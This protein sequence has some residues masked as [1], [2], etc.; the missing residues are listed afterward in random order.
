MKKITLVILMC[1]VALFA[2][3]QVIMDES[4]NYS[5][6]SLTTEPSW[7]A[8]NYTTAVVGT[9]GDLS[10]DPLSYGDGNGMYALS[11]VGK[12]VTSNYTSGA[13]D[14]K[15]VKSI[16]PVSSGVIYMSL[17]FKPGVAQAQ[18]N[19]E[20]MCLS[21][22]GS[23]GPKVLIGKG[24]I[25]TT[26]FRFATTRASSSS[27]DYKWA[28]TEYT[29]INQTFLLVVKYDWSNS[30]A[31]L[32]V[33]PV[34][35]S[36]TEPT[37]DVIDNNGGP[38][39]KTVSAPIDG[40]RFR[41]NGASVSKFMVS[42]VRISSSWAAAVGKQV[43][44]LSSPTANA[45]SSVT[46]NSFTANWTPVANAI[47]YD[48]AVYAGSTLL[49]TVNATGQSTSSLTIP[50]L[51]SNTAYTYQVTAVADK[52]TF[53]NSAP[54]SSSTVVTTL[55]LTA[56]TAAAATNISTSGFTANWSS[57]SSA[58]GYDI[59]LL[60]N[61]TQ[62][63]TINVTGG[64]VTSY[65]FTQL[66]MG[67]TYNYKVVAKGNGSGILDSTPSGTIS[68]NTLSQNIT[69]ATTDFSQVAIWGNPI[70]TPSTNLPLSGYYPTW[71]AAGFTFEKAVSYANV[72][73]GVKGET[74][75]NVISFDKL[76]T[77]DIIFPTINSL[78][79]IE[80]HAYSGSDAKVIALEE[81]SA[82]GTTWNPINTYTTNKLEA[83]YIENLSR[84]APSTF[85]LRNNG[86][87]SMNVSQIILRP[88]LPTT[89]DLPAPTEIGAAT[90]IN[91]GAFTAS[92]TPVPNA[93]GYIV[94]VW[95][96]AKPLAKNFTVTGQA[97]S[98]YNVVGLDSAS[99]CT[100][101]VAAIGDGIVYSNSLLSAPSASFAI[102]AGL[103]AVQ[104]LEVSNCIWSDGNVINTSVAG[105]LTVY[106]VQ[107]VQVLKEAIENKLNT[108]LPVGLYI[109]RLVSLD[110][111]VYSKK[112][113]IR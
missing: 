60:L 36:A 69:S 39:A 25:T 12:L 72:Q 63:A 94:S 28:T 90:G 26:N 44:A 113:L 27:A 54:S 111:T 16:S 70:P 7:T 89:T 84:T 10:S 31:S 14:Y 61:T 49:K 48:V 73:T 83:T 46:N 29:D 86:T 21:I 67:T 101:K 107:G 43:P 34:I 19:S 1:T 30:T 85:R 32:F 106:N 81:L 53:A 13:T 33:N 68:C 109:I 108:K 41:V 15:L 58:T 11:S 110:G 95:N 22:A 3:A 9:I 45:A 38:G 92:W 104:N 51:S 91:P 93:T 52:I 37:A 112:L 50:G 8:L 62:V 78:A 96:Y 17:L 99:L 24:T 87:T 4:F 75:V 100:Y 35:G 97:T 56:P 59:Y 42:G 20:I 2:S 103:L 105:N 64:N 88:T 65:A 55:G 98:S 79:Q 23:N 18:A 74:H 47:S 80:F 66:Q 102:T 71:K 77:A 82:D 40:F 5:G 57:V 6:A 76:T